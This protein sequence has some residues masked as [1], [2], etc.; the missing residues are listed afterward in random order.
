MRAL[1]ESSNPLVPRRYLRSADRGDDRQRKH[2]LFVA[3][4]RGKSSKSASHCRDERQLWFQLGDEYYRFG[5]HWRWRGWTAELESPNESTLGSC[6]EFLAVSPCWPR[7]HLANPTLTDIF[8]DSMVGTKHM[9]KEES[10]AEC[11]GGASKHTM[12]GSTR[13]QLRTATREGLIAPGFGA[14]SS[15]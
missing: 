2:P 12:P 7:K 11:T 14:E 6:H 4:L 9:M 8:S 15:F 13:V 1:A 3:P 10:A 5:P